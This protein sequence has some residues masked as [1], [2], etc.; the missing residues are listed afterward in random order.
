MVS[1]VPRR[2]ETL[3]DQRRHTT[4]GL[5]EV[6]CLACLAKVWVRKNSEHHTSIQWNGE[7]VQQCPEFSR[8]DRGPGGR[9]VHAG[10]P[11]M[12]ASIESVTRDGGIPIGAADDG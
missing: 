6:A 7:A 11:R 8:M 2:A 5:T 1:A 9:R 4:A 3:E 10:C 12:I